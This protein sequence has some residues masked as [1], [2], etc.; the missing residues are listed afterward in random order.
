MFGKVG[1]EFHHV[2]GVFGAEEDGKFVVGED[3]AAVGGVLKVVGF[4]VVP[5]ELCGIG[6]RCFANANDC[7]EG[8]A[9]VE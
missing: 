5:E 9:G 1:G 2:D 7:F 3:T 4:D 8:G 6:A